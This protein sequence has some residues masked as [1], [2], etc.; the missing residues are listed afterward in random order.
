MVDSICRV[1]C[2]G[3]SRGVTHAVRHDSLASIAAYRLGLLSADSVEKVGLW[4]NCFLAVQKCSILA[5][6]RKNQD[7]YVF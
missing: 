2:G 1:R 4:E 7:S 6:L 3:L 5:L